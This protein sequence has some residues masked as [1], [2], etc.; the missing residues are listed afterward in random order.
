MR[1]YNEL[2]L[3]IDRLQY[4]CIRADYFFDKA[5]H[6]YGSIYSEDLSGAPS[7]LEF[8]R[9]PPP[10]THTCSLVAIHT[11]VYS[12]SCTLYNGVPSN[13]RKET[14]TFRSSALLLAT[15]IEHSIIK[16]Q[17]TE[18]TCDRFNSAATTGTL[19]LKLSLIIGLI[20]PM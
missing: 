16:D 8:K 3:L 7:S 15:S 14:R 9:C 1:K 2:A 6:N 12:S 18:I 4:W 17:L 13:M 20:S 19:N 5:V 10:L 11:N